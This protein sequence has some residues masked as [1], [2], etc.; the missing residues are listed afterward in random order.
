M[1]K[2]KNIKRFS[3]NPNGDNVGIDSLSHE[4]VIKIGAE[5]ISTE[6]TMKKILVNKYP[7][8]LIDESQDTKKELIDA[9]LIVYKEKKDQWAIGMFGDTMQKIYQDGKDRLE[10]AIP[11]DWVRPVKVM[12]HRSSM[13]SPLFVTILNISPSPIVLMRCSVDSSKAAALAFRIIP[14]IFLI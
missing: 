12:N 1:E 7:V 6:E 13:S 11:S 8:L 14:H 10:E 3:Y 5:F 9:L 2:I 4:E